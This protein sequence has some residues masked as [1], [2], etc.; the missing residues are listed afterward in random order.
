MLSFFS[1]QPKKSQALVTPSLSA[2]AKSETDS[3]FE[4]LGVGNEIISDGDSPRTD[5]PPPLQNA[6]EAT[7]DCPRAPCPG[8]VPDGY[9]A[10][11]DYPF[12]MHNVHRSTLPWGVEVALGSV[13]F[14]ALDVDGFS[15][16]TRFC[17]QPGASCRP[18][19]N[20]AYCRKF[21]VRKYGIT[22]SDAHARSWT[23]Q[24]VVH[25]SGERC[26]LEMR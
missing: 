9:I 21:R 22:V 1:S 18:C 15:D 8:F 23:S 20:L 4:C 10:V 17:P 26:N 16:C 5:P 2:E 7:A 12:S 14:R 19:A 3:D 25:R 11:E 13:R 6:I 24:R